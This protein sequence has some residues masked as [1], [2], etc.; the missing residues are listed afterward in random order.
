MPKPV[1]RLRRLCTAAIAL[2]LAGAGAAAVPAPAT[3]AVGEEVIAWLEVEQGAISGGPAYNSGD[4]GNFS[5]TGS[6]TFRET[7]M[8][9]EMTVTAPVAGAYPVWIRY[10]AGPLSAEENITRGMG[11]LT[12]GGDRRTVPYPLTGSWESWAWAQATVELDEGANTLALSCDRAVEMC[13]LNFDAVQVGGPAPDPC[14]VTPAPAGTTRLFDGS[15]A[16]FD[17]WRKAGSGGFGQQVVRD[18]ATGAYDCTLRGFRGQGTTWTTAQHSGPYTLGVDWRRGDAAAGSS[19]YV[20]STSNAAATPAGGYRVHIGATDTGAVTYGS[21]TQPADATAVAAAVRPVGQWNRFAV[22]VTPQRIRVLLNGTPVNAVDRTAATAGHIGLE[23]RA[24]T[25]QV[26]FR[27][28]QLTS[29]VV[30]GELSG[31][32]RRATTAQGA[33]HPGDESTLANLVADSQRWATRGSTG[34]NARIALVASTSLQAD[35]VPA[36]GAVT[37]AAATSVVSAEPLVNLRLTGAQVETVLEQQWQPDGGFVSLGASAGLTWT[38]DPARP[39]GDRIT[40]VWLDGVPLDPA[41]NYSVTA[42]ASLAAGSDDFPGFAAGIGRRTPDASTHSALAAHVGDAS[43]GG[44]FAVPR[45]QRGI[46]VHVPGGATSW[47]AGTT[48]ALDL[49]SW[50]YSATSDPVDDTVDVTVGGRSVGSFAVEDGEADPG[51]RGTIAV[52]AA[53]PVDLPTG[54]TTVEVVGSATGTTLR[55][56]VAVTAAPAEPPSVPTPGTTPLPATTTPT[57]T[58]PAATKASASLRVRVKPGRVVARKT[59]AR[60]VVTVSGGMSTPTGKVTA[61]LGTTNVRG[62]LREGRVVLR[63][64]VLARP[65]RV[66]VT[67]AYA[68]DSRTLAAKR[69]LR[70]R[71]VAP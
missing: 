39:R 49:S 18:P 25:D 1:H 47:Q 55:L 6:Y 54:A 35:L 53:L 21:T 33:A 24:G 36:D 61:K 52:R 44:P 7:G 70:I 63:L 50:S 31:P 66:T 65:G 9:S 62:T 3:A 23:N 20:A 34:G 64:P 10:A 41:L 46:G 58:P 68:G 14:T 16:S 43:A 71:A 15:F 56:P 51:E 60:L 69:A 8:T 37:Y 5:G 22:Q 45:T 12:N 28:I 19:V 42:A 59:R 26:G 38:H 2:G 4:H 27:D 13:R 67:V 32:A 30:L 40:G 48:Y 17:Q 29:G 57:T 11:L